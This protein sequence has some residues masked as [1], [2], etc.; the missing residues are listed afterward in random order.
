MA[1]IPAAIR[2]KNPGAMW[3]GPIATKWGSVRFE[4]LADG[5]GQG[6]KIAIFDT[7][8]QGICAQ[9]DLW[10]S[11]PRYRNKRFADAIA[12]WSGGNSVSQYILYVKQRVAGMTEDTVMNDAFWR[13]PMAIPFLQAQSGHEA[14]QRIPAPAEDW[15]AAQK[16]VMGGTTAPVVKSTTTTVATNTVTTTV[17]VQ[18]AQQGAS[19]LQIAVVIGVGL[20]LVGAA[21]W[22]FHWRKKPASTDDSIAQQRALLLGS[23]S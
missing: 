18:A 20:I 8:V 14:G 19:L 13:G 23:G 3:P 10:R 11:S 17:A 15:V 7:W 2:S 21:Y 1:R 4:S 5:T 16:K 22:W 9:L 12:V 6:N